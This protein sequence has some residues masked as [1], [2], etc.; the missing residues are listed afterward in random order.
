[1]ERENTKEDA[2]SLFRNGVNRMK[3]Q[4]GQGRYAELQT[5]DI[6][7]HHDVVFRAPLDDPMCGLPLGDGSTGLLVWPKKDALCVR[8]N[9]TDCVDDTVPAGAHLMGNDRKG[10]EGRLRGG[11]LRE[12]QFP[13]PIFESA[14]QKEY[15]ARLSLSDAVASVHAQTPFAGTDIR[16]FASGVRNV[17]VMTISA[18]F[19]E[20]AEVRAQLSRWGSRSFNRWYSRLNGTIGSGLDGTAAIA[21]DGCMCI[22]QE[23]HGSAF[24]VAVLPVSQEEKR[25]KRAHS[26]LLSTEF[27]AAEYSEQTYYIAAVPAENTACAKEKAL[28]RLRMAAE[29]GAEELYREHA[30]E[31]TVFWNKSYISLPEKQDFLENIW[32]LNLYYA[33]C[34]M[35][36]EYPHLPW[37]GVWGNFYDYSPWGDTLH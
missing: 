2:G 3:I 13:F 37:A 14:Y 26:R 20:A 21:E 27:A 31:W 35:R 6:L 19:D 34:Q 12:V 8:I 32:Y 9:H 16:I 36:G 22:T 24:C 1:M 23:L 10:E 7:S 18:E 5:K 11:A 15:E 29:L 4:F 28:S 30:E 25:V 33:N 17:A